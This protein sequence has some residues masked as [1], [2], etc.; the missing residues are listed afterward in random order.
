L[1]GEEEIFIEIITV[2]RKT[3]NIDN[4]RNQIVYNGKNAEGRGVL[5]L[6]K[7]LKINFKG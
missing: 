7:T 6:G 3:W 1:I 4:K 2:R 5:P